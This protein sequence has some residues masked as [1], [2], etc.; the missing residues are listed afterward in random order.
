MNNNDD[1]KQYNLAI[2]YS[3]LQQQYSDLK[4]KYEKHEKRDLCRDRLLKIV[5]RPI[6]VCEYKDYLKIYDKEE[7]LLN[8]SERRQKRIIVSITSY[9]ARIKKAPIAIAS[10][11]LQSMKPDE[12]VVWLAD[13]DFPDRDLPSIYEKMKKCGVKIEFRND[14]K[15]HMKYHYAL[16]EYSDDIVI[17]IDDDVIYENNVI[18]RLYSSYQ[19]WPECISAIS[20][21]LISFDDNGNIMSY[22]EWFHQCPKEDWPSI[23]LMACGVGGVLYPPNLKLEQLFNTENVKA[24]CPNADDI[25]LRFMETLYNIKVV[26]AARMDNSSRRVIRGTQR[27]IALGIVNMLKNGNNEQVKN[28][29]SVYDDYFK[30]YGMSLQRKMAT[31]KYEIDEGS[32]R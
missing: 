2:R 25:W 3:Q 24:L 27:G 20:T 18:K 28:I 31:E 5:T 32:L 1:I 7:I 12:V 8:T 21:D 4:R 30:E 14:L 6:E 15:V 9:P 23:R 29:I 19:K 10:I 13:Q 11:L 26:H 17:T 16:Q 22:E